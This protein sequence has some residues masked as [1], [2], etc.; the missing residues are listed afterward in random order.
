M[1]FT[2]TIRTN[3]F[4]LK[5]NKKYSAEQ[6]KL[7]QKIKLLHQSG[8]GYRKI[9]HKLNLE[10]IRTHRGNEWGSNNVYSV[11]KRYKEREDRLEF[12]NREYEPL[13]GKMVVGWKI[14]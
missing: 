2:V 7:F 9:A 10:N 8:F 12:M 11:L 1:C 14:C 4:A 6:E 5:Q 3:K 13:W